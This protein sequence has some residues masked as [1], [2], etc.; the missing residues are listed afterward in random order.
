VSAALVAALV[1]IGVL[2]FVALRS[3]RRL[4]D[5][6]EPSPAD[7]LAAWEIRRGRFLAEQ[8]HRAERVRQAIDARATVQRKIVPRLPQ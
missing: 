7:R 1:S 4:V 3:R 8:R 6:S 5:D 2:T